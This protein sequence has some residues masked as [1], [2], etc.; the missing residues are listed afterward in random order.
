MAS[1]S[2]DGDGWCLGTHNSKFD[3]IS[4]S[5]FIF[6]ESEWEEILNNYL[7]E[8]YLSDIDCV[9]FLWGRP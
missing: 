8:T 3:E 9:K 7:Q 5:P 6:D 4:L 2:R 1:C